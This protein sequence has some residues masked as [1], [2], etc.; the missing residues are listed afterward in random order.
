M[1]E[2]LLSLSVITIRTWGYV[3][4]FISSFLE[5]IPFLGILNP[6]ATIAH[7]GGF[8]AH[9]GVLGLLP[10]IALVFAGLFLGDITAYL[11]GVRFGYPLLVRF[12]TFFS[13]DMGRVERVR[14]FVQDHTGKAL[15]LGRFIF[16]VRVFASFIAGTAGCKLPRFVT[17]SFFGT[18]GWSFFLVYVGFFLGFGF[19]A[20]AAKVGSFFLGA[21]VV[22]IILIV[23]FR[24]LYTSYK[25]FSR[26][27]TYVFGSLIG[28]LFLLG[29]LIEDVASKTFFSQADAVAYVYIS[30]KHF[31]TTFF[32][33]Y[34]TIASLLF[35]SEVVL[36]VTV[37]T[38]LIL[39]LK[40]MRAESVLFFITTA[41]AFVL[42][43]L[44]KEIL[45][46]PRP[47]EA[48]LNIA[49][50]AFPSGH[51]TAATVFFLLTLYVLCYRM[52]DPFSLFSK[53]IITFIAFG[54]IVSVG[55][56]RMYLGVHWFSDV[57]GGL[58]LGILC[59][60]GAV[61]IFELAEAAL[62][63]RRERKALQRASAA[64]S[65]QQPL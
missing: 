48:A 30:L 1:V 55:L 53:V 58:A 60:S 33:V 22:G 52:K 31:H 27:E 29:K 43:T 11:L 62:R 38:C 13:I 61:L 32:D 16:P 3:V 47:P 36:A 5:S 57:L 10:V 64:I 40:R 24:Y 41:I 65:P 20:L 42:A 26:F 56:S 18:L 50:Y 35:N 49:S 19:D 12:S 25:I 17:Y 15:T 45:K 23:G 46:F 39:F 28:S 21:L 63:D 59:V 51:V 2:Y 44:L 9:Q 4:L 8:F 7:I 14:L 6:G 37:A 54:G 34:F